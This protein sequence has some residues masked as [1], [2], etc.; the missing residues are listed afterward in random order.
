MKPYLFVR[1]SPPAQKKLIGT[2]RHIMKVESNSDK[3]ARIKISSIIMAMIIANL[4][5]FTYPNTSQASILDVIS[6]IFTTSKVSASVGQ[7][8]KTQSDPAVMDQRLYSKQ[9]LHSATNINPNPNKDEV[10]MLVVSGSALLSESG[11]AGTTLDIENEPQNTQISTYKVQKGDNLENIAK[12]FDVSVN[13]IV[14]ANDLNRKAVLQEGQNLTILPISGVKY[15]IKKGDTLISI[16]KKLGADLDEITRF[17]DMSDKSI[18]IPGTDIIIPD[19]ES[20]TNPGGGD[21]LNYAALGSTQ[22][23]SPPSSVRGANAPSYPGYYMRPISGGTITQG[24]HGYNAVDIGAESGTP[25]YAA[26]TGTVI[27][28]NTG[29]WHGGYGNYVVISHSNGTQTLYAH[30]LKNLVSAGDIVKKGQIIAQVGSTGKS[31]GSHLHFEVHA[32]KNFV[33]GD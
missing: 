18:L 2:S 7:D 25:I 33:L 21:G 17:N 23:N 32:G 26:A 6:N 12:M 9:L 27:V 4:G 20:H 3:S 11:P 8:L 30:T 5:L 14:W 22:S 10:A 19:I 24:L 28:S 13:T 31:T 29:G 1:K 16:A 15:T